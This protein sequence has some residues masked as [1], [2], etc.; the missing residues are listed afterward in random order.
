MQHSMVDTT[1]MTSVILLKLVVF[2]QNAT[3]FSRITDVIYMV[4]DDS[5][6]IENDR[7]FDV[8]QLLCT[9]GLLVISVLQLLPLSSPHSLPFPSTNGHVDSTHNLTCTCTHISS[10][11]CKL[12]CKMIM[13]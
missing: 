5:P 10:G 13:S 8:C 9:P 2:C 1:K 11:L 6:L 12:L 4:T 3:N 7:L